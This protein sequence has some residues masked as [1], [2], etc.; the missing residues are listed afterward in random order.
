MPDKYFFSI[1]FAEEKMKIYLALPVMNEFGNLPALLDSLKSQSFKNF[2]LFICV[3]QPDSWWEDED[4]KPVCHDNQKSIE[5][6]RKLKSFNLHIIDRSSE[7]NAWKG[8]YFGV[9][10]ARKTAMEA[11]DQQAEKDDLIVSID[12]DTSY[13]P[14][15]RNIYAFPLGTRACQS[16]LSPSDRQGENRQGHTALRDLHAELQ[17]QH[18]VD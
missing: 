5:F 11:I 8:N 18:A 12:A 9:G 10:W 2:D 14:G 16:L 13:P 4:R 6:L 7:G 15:Y 3:N 1:Y 17:Y